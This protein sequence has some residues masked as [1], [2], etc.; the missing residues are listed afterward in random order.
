[1]PT[2]ETNAETGRGVPSRCES[3]SDDVNSLWN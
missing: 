1:M 2:D 3:G